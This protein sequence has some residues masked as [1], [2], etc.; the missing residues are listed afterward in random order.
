MSDPVNFTLL[1][2]T[3]WKCR[4]HCILWLFVTE[5]LSPEVSKVICVPFC[6]VRAL[7]DSW[8]GGCVW[9][10]S[11]VTELSQLWDGFALA[12]QLSILRCSLRPQGQ[13]IWQ[14]S[15]HSCLALLT[16]RFLLF[17]KYKLWSGWALRSPLSSRNSWDSLRIGK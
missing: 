5:F 11:A 9:Q 14:S 13:H 1:S 2:V 16:F 3:T 6:H 17:I 15:P 4:W 10:G 7:L 8:G 12:E